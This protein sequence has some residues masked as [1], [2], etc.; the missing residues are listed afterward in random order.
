MEISVA[1]VFTPACVVEEHGAVP[2]CQFVSIW[3]LI[4]LHNVL[5]FTVVTNSP[6]LRR[7]ELGYLQLVDVFENDDYQLQ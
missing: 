3:L 1:S 6:S 4:G 7:Q 2:T 5:F